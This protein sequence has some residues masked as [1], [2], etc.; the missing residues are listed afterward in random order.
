LFPSTVRQVR[1]GARHCDLM[2]FTP[3]RLAARIAPS[4]PESSQ[5]SAWTY[6]AQ[7]TYDHVTLVVRKRNGPVTTIC[8]RSSEAPCTCENYTLAARKRN[9][10]VETVCPQCSE[11]P[12]TCENCALAAR[13][14]N[15]PVETVC[16]RSSEAP[17]TWEIMPL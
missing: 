17:R 1:G 15:G 6:Q 14:R 11:A 12:Y 5:Q 3:L 9:G 13:K 2:T 8:R 16:P 4:A 7:R 10:P